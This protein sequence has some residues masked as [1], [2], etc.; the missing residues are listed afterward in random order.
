MFSAASAAVRVMRRIAEAYGRSAW[1]RCS[2]RRRRAAE[3]ISIARV[4]FWT[5][6]T[7]AIRPRSSFW[8]MASRPPPRPAPAPAS[9][10]VAVAVASPSPSRERLRST[11]ISS[12]TG[13]PSSSRSKP[14]S[15]ANSFTR[16]SSR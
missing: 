12:S 16:S 3:I 13:L 8:A 7:E 11:S 4:I 9:P 15:S 5:F 1:M 2:A 14:K 6:L 10:L